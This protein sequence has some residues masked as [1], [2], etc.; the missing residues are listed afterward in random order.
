MPTVLVSGNRAYYFAV[1]SLAVAV[2]TV[3]AYFTYAWK[4]DPR[5][6]WPRWFG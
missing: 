5:V 2:I 6:R 3:A 4:D 1:S